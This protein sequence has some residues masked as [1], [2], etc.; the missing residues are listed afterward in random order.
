M[1]QCMPHAVRVL[2]QNIV[3]EPLCREALLRYQLRPACCKHSLTPVQTDHNA[4]CPSQKGYLLTLRSSRIL[5]VRMHELQ[6]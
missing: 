3:F 5:K 4:F 6:P 2:L 1:G